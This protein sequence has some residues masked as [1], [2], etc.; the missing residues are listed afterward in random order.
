MSLTLSIKEMS[1]SD[2]ILTT[3]IA[4][5]EYVG[6]KMLKQWGNRALTLENKIKKIQEHIVECFEC[7]EN[8]EFEKG[9]N[10]ALHFISNVIVNG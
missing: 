10:Q 6:P 7:G 5:L 1:L 3:S 8:D 9:Y 4:D 2:D